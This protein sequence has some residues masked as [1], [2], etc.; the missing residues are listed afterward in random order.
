MVKVQIL[1]LLRGE[2]TVLNLPLAPLV[3]VF[4]AGVHSG[5][6]SPSNTSNSSR[7]S[8]TRYLKVDFRF[9]WPE[10]IQELIVSTVAN[11]FSISFSTRCCFAKPV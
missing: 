8:K 10:A 11:L 4:C 2:W 9:F 1:V 3:E 5:R 7:I 6:E